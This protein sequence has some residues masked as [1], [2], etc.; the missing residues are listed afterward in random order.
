MCDIYNF[1]IYGKV[2]PL[3]KPKPKTDDKAVPASV[4]FFSGPTQRS[5]RENERDWQRHRCVFSFVSSSFKFQL[6]RGGAQ[7]RHLLAQARGNGPAAASVYERKRSEAAPA[8]RITM[9]QLSFWK[10]R[11]VGEQFVQFLQDSGNGQM[12]S[13]VALKTLYN[14]EFRYRQV[15]ECLK[16]G[17]AEH[18]DVTT[19]FFVG[20]GPVFLRRG[21]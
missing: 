16:N 20:M 14:Q 12:N 8:K 11:E 21:V 15:V 18:C 3:R 2:P 5:F 17:S 4:S 1:R 9:P 7:G 6:S 10:T 13:R 19:S